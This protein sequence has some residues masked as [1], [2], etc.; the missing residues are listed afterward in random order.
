M[1][2]YFFPSLHETVNIPRKGILN[3]HCILVVSVSDFYRIR[4]YIH[5]C[6]KTILLGFIHIT[7]MVCLCDL[8][9]VAS[10]VKQHL[11]FHYQH[12]PVNV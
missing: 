4:F 1:E 12:V 5:N 11:M 9:I 3:I 8:Y 7:T 6:S 10:A 2:G